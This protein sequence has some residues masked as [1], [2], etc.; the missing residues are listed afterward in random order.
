M[1]SNNYLVIMAGGKG[2][3]FWP[4]SRQDFP[5]QFNDIL[6]TGRTLLQQ[7]VD[8]FKN[9]CP[10]ENVYVVTN[11]SYKHIIEEQIPGINEHQILLEPTQRNTA[12]CIAYASYKIAAENTKARIV[13]SPSDHAIFDEDDFEKIIITSLEEV[14]NDDKLITLGIQPTR[15][16]T[17]YGYIQYLKN[18]T[19][20]K[21]VKTFT[22]KPEPELAKK[23]V[24]SGDFV[25]NAGI[26]VWNVNAIKK[27]FKQYLPDVDETFDTISSVFYTKDEQ[28]KIDVAYSLCK[29]ISIDYGIMEKAKN[30]YVA[31]G[32]FG[33][34]DIGSW[35]SLYEFSDKNREG[36]V[37]DGNV[38]V[39]DSKNCIIK[40]SK[41]KLIIIEGLE[42]FLVAEHGNAMIICKK[43]HESRF[44]EFIKDV[45]KLKGE[46]FL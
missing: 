26:F 29:S 20:L 9:V 39:Y 32:E 15:P 3:R 38:M 6:G 23:F 43:D 8:R 24:E 5:K 19:F 45:K 31:L 7:T 37:I 4:A 42:D 35:N 25:W 1:D 27:A 21:K 44:R 13:V 22:E 28:D 2:T 30:V 16:E 46:E 40:T 34:S 18:D 14:S 11:K 17:G 10:K 12:P 33:W 36:N 41:D